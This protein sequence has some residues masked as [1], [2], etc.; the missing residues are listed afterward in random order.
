MWDDS[1]SDMVT[2]ETWSMSTEAFP[3]SPFDNSR[4]ARMLGTDAHAYGNQSVHG[5]VGANAPPHQP[6]VGLFHVLG[7]SP[8][9]SLSEIRSAYRK[10]VLSCHPDKVHGS[11]EEKVEAQSKF[12]QIS[13]AYEILTRGEDSPGTPHPVFFGTPTLYPNETF[14]DPY[15]LFRNTFG[16]SLPPNN[17]II[18]GDSSMLFNYWTA[19]QS[20]APQIAGYLTNEP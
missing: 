2:D 5:T 6:E 15:E 8:G 4:D 20:A 17:S 7:V 12:A 10:L 16:T 1:P 14:T 19:L 11:P 9:A 3:H 18:M 13:A